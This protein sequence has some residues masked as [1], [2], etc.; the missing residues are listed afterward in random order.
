MYE[1]HVPKVDL[2]CWLVFKS[3]KSK[4]FLKI[5]Q[6]NECVCVFFFLQAKINYLVFELWFIPKQTLFVWI[7]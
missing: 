4:F 5:I 3:K 6:Q 1:Y 2:F 7:F